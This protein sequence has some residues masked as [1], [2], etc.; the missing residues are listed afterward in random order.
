MKMNGEELYGLR[1]EF[2]YYN[3]V[4]KK[5]ARTVITTFNSDITSG[6]KAITDIID[7][8][9][10]TL[11]CGIVQIDVYEALYNDG[12]LGLGELKS[13]ELIKSFKVCQNKDWN[14]CDP[15]NWTLKDYVDNI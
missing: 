1:C 12:E 15:T 14:V 10:K 11:Y 8:D 3:N 2:S 7:R 5:D 4:D 13:G 6:T 9:Y